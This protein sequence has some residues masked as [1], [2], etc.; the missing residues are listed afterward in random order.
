MFAQLFLC[1]IAMIRDLNA[2][3]EI[4]RVFRE[5]RK[6]DLFY[7]NKHIYIIT[8]VYIVFDLREI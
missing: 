7:E 1:V 2:L 8:F 6:Y 3:Q 5:T 4:R